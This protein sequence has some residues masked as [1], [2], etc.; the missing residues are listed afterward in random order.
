MIRYYRN[1][2]T[3]AVMCVV[4]ALASFFMVRRERYDSI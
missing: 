2:I 4:L 3:L 1:L